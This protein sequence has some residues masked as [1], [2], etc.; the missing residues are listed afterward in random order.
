VTD[1]KSSTLSTYLLANVSAQASGAIEGEIQKITWP[2]HGHVFNEKRGFE[3][4][5]GETE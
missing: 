2:F 3:R 4:G 5:S 1:S